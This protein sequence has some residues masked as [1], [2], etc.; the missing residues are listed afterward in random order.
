MFSGTIVCR[1]KGRKNLVADFLS[2]DFSF[3]FLREENQ[4]M[5]GKEVNRHFQRSLSFHRIY[6]SEEKEKKPNIGQGK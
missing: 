3:S 6:F 1:K 2:H 4:H 5:R